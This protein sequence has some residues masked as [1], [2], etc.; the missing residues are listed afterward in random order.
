MLIYGK[1]SVYEAI[2]SGKPIE[3]IVVSPN[4]PKNS[5][6]LKEAKELGIKIQIIPRKIINK[7][8]KTP[9]NQG[10]VAYISSIQPSSVDKIIE[11]T[12][13][14]KDS[15]GVVLDHITDIQNA[16]NIIRTAECFNLTGIIIPKDRGFPLN[17][18]L[19]KTSS[20]AIFHIPVAKV[21]NLGNLLENFKDKGGF[22]AGIEIGGINIENFDPVTPLIIVM[23]SEG[24][25][26]SQR[27]KN[28]CDWILTIPQYGKINSL[29][30]SSAFAIATYIIKQKILKKL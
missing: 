16:G 1:N 19:V 3:K 29:N 25:G 18:T 17:E 26:I 2:K 14:R 13:K 15:F 10:I 9:K 4:F 7:L 22:V 6:I 28:I 8:T 27:I 23:G 30:V 21:A 5:K 24:H 12:I 20:G 11:D